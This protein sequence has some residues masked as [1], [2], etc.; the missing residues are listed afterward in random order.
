MDWGV[1]LVCLGSNSSSIILLY[2]KSLRKWRRLST[3]STTR[4]RAATHT[5]TTDRVETNN[6]RH[7]PRRL[8]ITN[9]LD[10]NVSW[11]DNEFRQKKIVNYNRRDSITKRNLNRNLRGR[12]W[13][14]KNFREWGPLRLRR[15]R[16]A[17]SLHSYDNNKKRIW[18]SK[19][20]RKPKKI[21]QMLK[22]DSSKDSKEWERKR[23]SMLKNKSRHNIGGK[24]L[25]KPRK[26]NVQKQLS[27][28]NK[29]KKDKK[30]Q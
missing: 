3:N 2:L 20:K 14:L 12:G 27:I 29:Y 9:S 11:R 6:H 16:R 5:R 22:I 13:S 17:M 24:S 26:C 8:V 19:R 21:K 7:S 28:V 18:K 1:R 10:S 23:K 15:R 25:K 4:R 30:T